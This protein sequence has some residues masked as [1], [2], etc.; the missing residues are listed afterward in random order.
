MST[1]YKLPSHLYLWSRI[2]TSLQS[3]PSPVHHPHCCH[4]SLASWNIN[5]PCTLLF[6]NLLMASHCVQ[7]KGQVPQH[8]KQGSSW[9]DLV[10]L[11]LQMHLLTQVPSHFMLQEDRPACDDMKAVCCFMPPHLFSGCPECPFLPSSSYPKSFLFF[12]T[13]LNCY[14]LQLPFLGIP[15]TYCAYLIAHLIVQL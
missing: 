3:C 11:S 13:H 7:N 12:K 2:W 5:W 14:L 15:I 8:G 1:S 9:P 6:K 10:C 4:S